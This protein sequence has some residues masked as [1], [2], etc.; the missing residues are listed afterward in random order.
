MKLIDIVI[1]AIIALI[2]IVTIKSLIKNKG[3]CNCSS[4]SCGS[5]DS[6]CDSKLYEEYKKN[7]LNS[8]N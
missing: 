8:K 3:T 7:N 1:I 4:S 6:H 2:V 5:C